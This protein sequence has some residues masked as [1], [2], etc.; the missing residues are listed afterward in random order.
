MSAPV[1]LGDLATDFILRRQNTALKA[2]L[3]T[4][5]QE[6]TTGVTADPGA[7]LGGDYSGFAAIEQSL[8]LLSRYAVNTAEAATRTDIM[9]TSLGQLDS[10]AGTVGEALLLAAEGTDTTL[11]TAAGLDAESKLAQSIAALNAQL[12]GHSLFAGA[13]TDAP[14]LAPA[15]TLL[16]DLRAAIGGAETPEAVLAAAETWFAAPDGFVTS[17]YTGSDLAAGPVRLSDGQSLALDLTAADPALRG[18]LA[19][20]AVAALLADGTLLSDD[21]DARARLARQTGSALIEAE[22]PLT[23]LRAELGAAQNRIET[24]KAENAAKTTMLEIARAELIGVDPYESATELEAVQGQLEALYT[25]T[26]RL[27]RLSLADM[28]S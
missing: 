1:S 10:A 6:V 5:A 23:A 24:I 11:V 27:S 28:L 14:A 20:L 4:L 17:A 3:S 26:A 19:G 22:G 2:R 25:I 7:R 16:A 12:G 15:E 18:T 13:A 9:Q 8:T 21:A